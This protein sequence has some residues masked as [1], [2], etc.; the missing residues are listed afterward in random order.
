[1]THLPQVPSNYSRRRVWEYM[2]LHPVERLTEHLR[3]GAYVS[4]DDLHDLWLLRQRLRAFDAALE[5]R[6]RAAG[7][8]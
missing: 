3:S 1:M 6:E 8:E 7:V 4:E 5:A 2:V